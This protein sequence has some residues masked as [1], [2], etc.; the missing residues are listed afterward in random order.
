MK[1]LT[2]LII[3][4]IIS[5]GLLFA[6]KRG[7]K[8]EL[9]LEAGPYY[10]KS[11]AS[12]RILDI[13]GYA[14][15]AHKKNGSNVQLWELDDGADRKVKFIPTE[16]GYYSIRF[17]HAKMNLDVHGCY[18]S[19]WFCWTY[20]RDKGANVQIWKAGNSKPQQWKV[21][22]VNPGQFRI[23]NRYSGKYLDAD[24]N[25]INK[26]GCNVLQWTWNG[27]DNQLWEIVDVESGQKY[28]E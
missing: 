6:Q 13:P 1:K 2:Y 20:K 25:N 7:K 26:N 5:Q 21:E 17:Q 8:V 14:S 22:Q 10:I 15:N 16:N 3:L 19:K 4:I 11:V 28:Q 27:R 12:G 18:D 9:N 23:Q 24:A